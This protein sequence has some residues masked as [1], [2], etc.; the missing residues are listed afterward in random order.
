MYSS[1]QSYVVR[2]HWWAQRWLFT[3]IV[4]NGTLPF[5]IIH[6]GTYGTTDYDLGFT[7]WGTPN[8][9]IKFLSVENSQPTK[10]CVISS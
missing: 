1:V 3:I 2:V 8:A 9:E 7:Q 4:V 5:I 6:H 10:Q